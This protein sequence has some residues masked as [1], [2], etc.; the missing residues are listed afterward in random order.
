MVSIGIALALGPRIAVIADADV[1]IFRPATTVR[2]GET[3]VATF[4]RPLLF[5]HVGLRATF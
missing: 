2:I 4:D 3:D 1:V 5:T